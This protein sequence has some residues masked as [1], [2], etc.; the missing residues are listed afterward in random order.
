MHKTFQPNEARGKRVR[1]RAAAASA[2]AAVLLAVLAACGGGSGSSS[3]DGGD[4]VSTAQAEKPTTRAEAARFLTQA[5]F[6]P[7]DADIDRVMA[8]GYGA[9]IDEQFAKPASTNRPLWEASDAA[10]KATNP[11]S[12]IYQDGTINAFWKNAVTAPDQLRQRV[13]YSLSQIFV[14]SMQDSTVGDN[15]RAAAAYLDMLGDKGLS[16]YRDLLEAVSKHPMMATYLSSLRNQKA[17][18]KTGRVPDE[19]YARE[20]MQLMS[21][22]LHQLNSDGTEQLANGQPVD[23]YGQ[24]DIAGMAKVFTGWSWACPEWPDNSCFYNG[25]A[26]GSSD[27]DRSFKTLLGYPQFHSL[28][29]KTFLGVT[30]GVQTKGDPDASLKTAL[31]TLANHGNVGP[32]IGKQLI[33][34]LVT[35]NPSPQYVAAVAAAFNGTGG[36]ARG[37]M[38]AV[39]KAVLMNP[40]ARTMSSTSGKLREPVLKLSAFL[41]AFPFT[42]DT[43]DYKVGNTDNAG[44]AL[45]QTPLRSGSVFNFYRPGYVPPGTEAAKAN[46][47]VP[48]MQ[49]AQETT[50][51][52]YVNYMRDNISSGVGS[53]NGT[54]N[55]TTYN[56]RDLQADY[57]NE[58]ALADNS[59]ALVDR[60]NDRLMYG[61]MPAALKTT[62]SGAVDKITIPAL[63]ASKTNQAQIDAAKLNRVRSAILLT[64]VSPEFQVQR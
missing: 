24:A 53:Y 62:I 14:I 27:P 39:V 17:D 55:G 15:P 7:T 47:A 31:D 57:S 6:G 28:E 33:Q 44:T 32:F 16:N 63:N 13:A 2:A 3:S 10:V 26:N 59:G 36:N 50:A 38:K 11:S 12:S 1:A 40:E 56:R 58:I 25:S 35:S 61:T 22:G 5:T 34:R 20:I 49:L 54:V 52:G 60:L 19:N 43:G 23:T 45:G 41:R 46:L 21:I 37:D 18:P 64:V 9:W 51:A 30:I 48:E 4:G 42:S 29:A 8:I